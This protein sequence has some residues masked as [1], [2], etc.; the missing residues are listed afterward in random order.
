MGAGSGRTG[1]GQ[2]R[3]KQAADGKDTTGP[4]DDAG[5]AQWA[6]ETEVDEQ[7]VID[8]KDL[9]GDDDDDDGAR[10]CSRAW[11][12]MGR[13]LSETRNVVFAHLPAMALIDAPQNLPWIQQQ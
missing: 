8:S 6:E 4:D 10:Y 9:R 11:I 12:P 7:S 1:K 13:T 2:A 5:S 3:D